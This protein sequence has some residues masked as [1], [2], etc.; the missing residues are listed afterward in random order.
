[1]INCN[2][3]QNRLPELL[4]DHS[5]SAEVSTHSEV[6]RHIAACSACRQEYEALSATFHLL[7]EWKAPEPS[8][9][10]DQRLAAHLREEMAA[11]RLGFFARLRDRFLF[12]SSF[13]LR[14]ALAGAFALALIVGGGTFAGISTYHT[15]N[16]V[17]V[18]PSAAVNDLQILDKN[19]QAIQQMDQLLEESSDAAPAQSQPAI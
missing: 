14:P 10:F 7:D 12:G 1:M 13:Q 16:T 15:D 3:C 8:A 18:Q 19:E 5:A 9:F 11:P 4:L 17:A 2:D 6:N